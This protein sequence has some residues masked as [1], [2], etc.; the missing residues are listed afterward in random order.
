MSS[1]KNSAD[2]TS[3]LLSG[4]MPS[5]TEKACK[6]V[7]LMLGSGDPDQFRTALGA[8]TKMLPFIVAQQSK[9]VVE[10]SGN[11]DGEAF[12]S[13][14]EFIKQSREQKGN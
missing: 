11:V 6:A 14:Q 2:I 8:Y 13:I 1:K 4:K 10:M 5:L 12:D 7:D 9:T 3:D